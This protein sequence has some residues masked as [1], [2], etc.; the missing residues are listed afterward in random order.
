MPFFYAI[1]NH[2]H[3]A[4]FSYLFP[5]YFPTS[6]GLPYYIVR[7]GPAAILMLDCG[8]DKPDSNES[9]SGLMRSDEFRAREAEWI[10]K[11]IE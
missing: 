7:Q 1:A 9:Y 8:E 3:L 4:L 11:A 10:E 5:D 6:N 2:A